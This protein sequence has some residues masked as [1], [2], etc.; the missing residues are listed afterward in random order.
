MW[1]A[2][3]SAQSS[4]TGIWCPSPHQP[5]RTRSCLKANTM[6]IKIQG[7]DN[8][9]CYLQPMKRACWSSEKKWEHLWEGALQYSTPSVW[10]LVP[11]GSQCHQLTRLW[12]EHH[13]CTVSKS[14]ETP[15]QESETTSRT[16]LGPVHSQ[17]MAVWARGTISCPFTLSFDQ[18]RRLEDMVRVWVVEQSV[19]GL[20]WI[21]SHDC[22]SRSGFIHYISPTLHN[23][24]DWVSC[25]P[26]VR[27]GLHGTHPKAL[28]P[29]NPRLTFPNAQTRL[30]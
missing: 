30:W 2:S 29:A 11:P 12:Y 18:F 16:C 21:E 24:L 27:Q 3:H 14:H 19:M 13:I 9:H 8:A 20:G 4:I 26:V 1:S 15:E 23:S 22:D 7:D 28:N 5:V 10:L 17:E 25:R 6:R